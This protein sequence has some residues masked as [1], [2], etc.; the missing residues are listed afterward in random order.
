MKGWRRKVRGVL[1]G[2]LWSQQVLLGRLALRTFLEASASLEPPNFR[3]APTSCVARESLKQNAVSS[4]P[5][6]LCFSQ[7]LSQ[8]SAPSPRP[9]SSQGHAGTP[10]LLP[11][12]W[13]IIISNGRKPFSCRKPLV[14]SYSLHFSKL[15]CSFLLS[16]NFVIR[17]PIGNNI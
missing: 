17:L 1:P 4:R 8:D 13:L 9:V 16:F 11:V 15:P 12:L 7:A 5:S 10:A 14:L 3:E 2:V 6:H